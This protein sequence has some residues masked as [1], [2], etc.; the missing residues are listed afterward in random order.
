MNT[1]QGRVRLGVG[2]E[3]TEIEA[4]GCIRDALGERLELLAAERRRVAVVTERDD[5]P[6]FL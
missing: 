1:Q 2:W 4:A 3:S 6:M 5:D